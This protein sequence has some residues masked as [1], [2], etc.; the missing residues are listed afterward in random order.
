MT[1]PLVVLLLIAR[2][3]AA[4]DASGRVEPSAAEVA[5]AA[6]RLDVAESALYDAVRR[7]PR[8]PSARGT[9]G[10]FLAARGR[11]RAGA[12][13]LEEARQFGAD[14]RTVDARLAQVYTWLGDWEA[15]GA[16]ASGVPAAAERERARWLASQRHDV[17]GPDSAQVDLAPN[18]L[19]GLGRVRIVVDDSATVADIDPTIT[20]LTLPAHVTS[21]S[22]RFGDVEGGTLVVVAR[23]GIG[24]MTLQNVPARAIGGT[25]AGRIGLDVLARL[26]PTF[27]VAARR[28]TLRRS[29]RGPAGDSLALWLALPGVGVAA[30]SGRPPASLASAEGR[31]AVRG[32]VWTFDLAHGAVV[33]VP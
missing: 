6:G 12:V 8:D 29:G 19:A 31:S 7:A 33:V 14:A 5:F 15:L 23:I 9:L 32:H 16:L 17:L 4:Q 26:T 28:L 1:R 24:S 13:L 21:T 18:E 11:L 3:L 20:G 2:T 27:D 30:R 25:T 10:G 22:P